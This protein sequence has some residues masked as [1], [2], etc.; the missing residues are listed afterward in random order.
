MVCEPRKPLNRSEKFLYKIWLE[1]SFPMA[2]LQ[3]VSGKSVS[4]I[5]TGIRNQ[6]EGPDF[7]NALIMVGDDLLSGDI[8]IHLKNKD[9]YLHGHHTDENYNEVVLHVIKEKSD[10]D[11]IR[12][13]AGNDVEIL[14][15]P[16]TNEDYPIFK[17]ACRTWSPV[18]FAKFSDLLQ[19]YANNR[20][21]RKTLAAR[22]AL[23]QIEPEQYFLIGLL[24]MMGYSRN[25]TGMKAIGKLLDIE[26][27]YS[28]LETL[29]EKKRLVFLETLLLGIAGLLNDDYQKYYNNAAYFQALQSE[30]KRISQNYG[31]HQSVSEKFHFAGSRP[32]NYPHK[33]LI[34]LAQILFNHYPR[35]PG[36]VS[37]EILFSGRKFDQILQLLREKFQLPAGMWKNH[38]I[39]QSH[40]SN[41]LIGDSRLMD[42]F[43][44]I[45]LPFARAL[46]SILKEEEQ[47]ALCIEFNQK[48]PTGAIPGKIKEMLKNLKV[49]AGKIKT[50]FLLQGC[51][52]YNRLFCDLELC[53]ICQ[54]RDSIGAK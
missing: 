45:L 53:N 31:F 46:C 1:K 9:W 41:L 26:K 24:D 16:I 42:F 17:P 30:W 50:N 33:R 34:A 21:R 29:E 32:A 52:E 27:L 5:N 20:F 49:P 22:K 19:D 12:T 36:Q 54:L 4:I 8:E 39:F 6:T 44:N 47:A 14:Q 51:I 3:T 11:F 18:D 48:V 28:I 40:K 7:K 25:R 37:L 10:S 23:L 43:T 2:H 38:P 13:A 15:L 35:K